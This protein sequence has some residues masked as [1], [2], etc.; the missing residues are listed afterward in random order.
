MA[1]ARIIDVPALTLT[2]TLARGPLANSSTQPRC[3]RPASIPG[4]L[5][6]S[7]RLCISQDDSCTLRTG[8]QSWPSSIAHM[9]GRP[10]LY[11]SDGSHLSEASRITQAPRVDTQWRIY[12]AET[13]HPVK[14]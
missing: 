12:V 14:A 6:R 11:T 13:Y 3:R 10:V 1:P 7:R 4:T 8:L 9:A 2:L 5:S